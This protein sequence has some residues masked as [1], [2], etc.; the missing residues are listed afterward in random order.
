LWTVCHISDVARIY[1]ILLK[2]ILRNERLGYGKDGYYFVEAGE[3]SW[4]DISQG[5]ANAGYSKGV[6]ESNQIKSITPD[7]MYHALGISFL[8]AGMVEVIWGSK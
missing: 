7:E 3:I 4:L 1:D 6:F 8:D 2:K 5:I